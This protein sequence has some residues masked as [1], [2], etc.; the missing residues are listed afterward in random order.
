MTPHIT[1]CS[2]AHT[3]LR[4]YLCCS[5]FQGLAKGGDDIDSELTKGNDLLFFGGGWSLTLS[6]GWSAVAQSRL[7]TTSAS[8][9]YAILLPQPPQYLELQMESHSV[10]QAG[11]KTV[12]SQLHHNLYLSSSKTWFRHVGQ[13][14]LELLTSGDPP[15]PASQS[16]GI[17]GVSHHV[18][19]LLL[20]AQGRVPAAQ[21]MMEST[22]VASDTTD[23]K[24]ITNLRALLRL[25]SKAPYS[26]IC[27]PI[28]FV[29]KLLGTERKSVNHCCLS[30]QLCLY[31]QMEFCSC[32]PGWSSMLQCRLTA[33]ST[34]WFKGFSSLSHPS[35]C[36][37]RQG[38]T[39]SPRLECSGKIMAQCKLNSWLKLSSGPSLLSRITA[40]LKIFVDMGPRYVARAGLELLAS[41]DLPTSASHSAGIWNLS[42]SPTQEC[43][44][45]ILAHCNLHLLGSKTGFHHIGLAGLELL[46][47]EDL[48]ALASQSAR[49]TGVSHHAQS[50]LYLTLSLRLECS[51]A[52]LALC[53]LCLQGS[54]DSPASAFQVSGIIGACHHAWP[55]FVFLVEMGFHHVGQGSLQLLTSGDLPA[56]AS[57]SP[58]IKG[59]S[60]HARLS[61]QFDLVVKATT[62]SHS[63][64][65]A[66]VQWYHLGS[67]QPPP[68]RFKQFSCLSLPSSWN[69]RHATPHSANFCIF[70]R[71]GVSSRWPGWSRTPDLSLGLPKCWACRHEPP[72]PAQNCVLKRTSLLLCG[73]GAGMIWGVEIKH[74]LFILSFRDIPLQIQKPRDEGRVQSWRHKSWSATSSE[75]LVCSSHAGA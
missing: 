25:L 52:N 73:V 15:T 31:H 70:S 22:P 41:D 71:D 50:P 61:L 20:L 60:H 3:T 53:N 9:V 29:E 32:P 48:H 46:T 21:G 2:S 24:M 57:R 8:Q 58:G 66:G 38:L 74:L 33:T 27:Q 34:S 17:T 7:T 19:P 55:I 4:I 5:P 56:L 51:G 23:W 43:S 30:K 6:P 65:Q 35:S 11:V 39:M 13:A 49:I 1:F 18:C 44:G 75:G 14:G 72:Q 63:V 37:Y 69:Y 54:S 68:P 16:A 10:T 12:P 45:V 64:T 42:L 28:I 59:V 40:N 67:L 47:S 36:D 62:E 26:S